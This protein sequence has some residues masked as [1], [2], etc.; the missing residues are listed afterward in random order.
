[1]S[2]LDGLFAQGAQ[3]LKTP[4][5]TIDVSS[6][7]PA[8]DRVLKVTSMD[9]PRAT[10]A[11]E[12]AGVASEFGR[13]GAVV[14]VPGDYSSNAVD[15]DSIV[16]GATVTDALETLSAS[17][18]APAPVSSVFGRTGVVAAVSGDYQA[19]KV[20]ND[21]A[22]T[23]S[24]VKA[25]L[26]ALAAAIPAPA[27]V[28]SVFGRTGVVA[29]VSGDYPASK[30]TNDSAVTGA[31]VKLA[32]ETLLALAGA[33]GNPYLAVPASPNAFD[34]EFNSGSP[35]LSVRGYTVVNSLGTTL[36]R[37]GDIDPWNA[38]GPAGNT[39]WSTLI[40][41]WLYLQ[42][43]PGVQIDFYKTIT[44]AAGDTY[45]CR[46]VGGYNLGTN[47]NGRFCEFGLYGASGAALDA[48]N[49]VFSTVRDDTT[50]TYLIY[51][52][53]RITASVQGGVTGRA[54]LGGHDIRGVRFDSGTTHS[55]FYMDSN[56][57]QPKSIVVTGAPAAGTL[58]R[59]G[60]R[61]LFSTA[62]SAVPQIWGV[63]F[64]RKKTSNAWLIP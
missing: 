15:T 54:A 37:S 58:T 34:D 24:T 1:M 53:A 40:G 23:G 4:S 48:N 17:I 59:V 43:A 32:L 16:P 39:Y 49:R 42:A 35:D 55:I 57:G 38:T 46:M 11:P 47:A 19:S 20:T 6:S 41:G 33:G 10:W 25:A 50:S 63:D 56:N 28:S 52:T 36:T 44:L 45:W 51:D 7:E 31:T 27:P 9:P 61:N 18:P 3:S 60:L 8:L 22:V 29:A 62:G 13:T 12:D 5:G 2:F 26:E 64:L 30:I 14:A 21:S